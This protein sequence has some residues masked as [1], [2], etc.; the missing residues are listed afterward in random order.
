M[1]QKVDYAALKKGGYMRQKQKGYGSLRLAVV[2]GNLT[3]ENIKTVAEV[4]EKY[5]RGYVHMTSRQGIEI[6]F[7]KVEELAEVKEALAKE[8]DERY[9]GRELPHKFKFGVT[10]CQN[11]CLKAEE[12]DVGIKGG[13]NI[14]YKEDDCI[15]CGVCVKACRQDALKMVDGKI[16]RDAQ[17]CNHCGRCVKSCPVDAWKGTSGYIVSFGGTFGNNIYKGEELLPLIPDKETLFRV[18]DAAIKFFEKNANPSERF[19]KTL[20]RVGE[21][22][23]RSQLKDAYEGQ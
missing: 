7:I 19:R 9:F 18:T 6:P 8:L 2:G 10:G 17:K 5:G 13:M 14:E 4:A 1:A 16:E 22:D 15:S 23:F 11:N 12:N 20:Q 3:A 21:E